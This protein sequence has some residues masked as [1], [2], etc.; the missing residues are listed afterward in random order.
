MLQQIHGG[1]IYRHPGV[2]DFSSNVNPLGTPEAVKEAV[3]QSVEQIHCYPDVYY[4]D[5]RHAIAAY[6]S[7]LPEQVICGNGAAELI[8]SLVMAKKPKRA[9]LPAPT[10]AEYGQALEASG[11]VITHYFMNQFKVQEDIYSMLT[12][13]VDILF[14]CN[15]NNPT[16]FLIDDNLLQGIISHCSKKGIFILLDECFLDFVDD[17][18]LHSMKKSL[19]AQDHLFILKAFT[20]RYAMAGIR[21]GYGLCGNPALLEHMEQMTQPWNVS[22]PA[23]LAGIA[24]LKETTYVSNAQHIVCEE[25]AYLKKELL[26]LHLKVYDSMANY[27]FF[28]GPADLFERC[29]ANGFLIRSCANYP[30]L[31]EGYYRI[32][33]KAHEENS[34]FV[35]VL[36]RILE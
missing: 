10:F 12:D 33:V 19:G 3:R 1:D 15:P 22:I 29:L 36:H 28:E 23:Q 35:E 21:L 25:R 18:E 20:K 31:K 24:A 13:D 5:L 14:L 9:I 6:E 7:V 11:C 30:G 2:I 17:G 4:S 27:I 16:G 32:A 26:D 8:F 34:R